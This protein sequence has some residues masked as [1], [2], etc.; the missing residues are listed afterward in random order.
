MGRKPQ[1][2]N[3]VYPWDRAVPDNLNV[4]GGSQWLDSGWLVFIIVMG[5]APA[6]ERILLA[7]APILANYLPSK[8]PSLALEVSP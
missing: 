8:H 5:L 6:Y 2:R 1:S 4:A 7:N 3:L